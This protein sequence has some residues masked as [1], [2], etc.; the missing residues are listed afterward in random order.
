M[1]SAAGYARQQG[2]T[3]H[4]A[5]HR[6]A[7]SLQALQAGGLTAEARPGELVQLSG[8][9]PATF[10]DVAAVHAGGYIKVGLAG[11]LPVCTSWPAEAAAGCQHL[12][13]ARAAQ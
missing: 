10:D 8:F 6:P 12:C 2:E 11:L 1:L 7:P 5:L 4:R 9:A 3:L 13:L